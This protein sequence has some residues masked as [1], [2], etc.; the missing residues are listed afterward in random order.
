MSNDKRQT[1]KKLIELHDQKEIDEGFPDNRACL[2]WAAEVEPLLSF[3]LLYKFRFNTKMQHLHH[4]AS[5][6][7]N[8]SDFQEMIS[9]LEMGIAKLKHEFESE[10]PIPIVKLNN[11]L[12][13]YVPQSRIKELASIGT[14]EFDLTKLIQFCN[15]L[16]SSLSEGNHFSI[17]MLSRAIL[18]H[19]PPVFGVESFH[20]IANNYKGARSFKESMERLNKSCRKIADQHLH[21]QIR[22][23]EV[24]PTI[25]QV[26]FSN[27]IDLLLSEIVRILKHL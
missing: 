7:S 9:I 19:I 21:S 13:E 23:S 22:G 11:P 16:N 26:D 2:S 6:N 8:T 24:L 15:E 3:D 1:L 27:D 25:A 12:R 10:T 17:I 20:E 14:K 4:N 5:S 18:D